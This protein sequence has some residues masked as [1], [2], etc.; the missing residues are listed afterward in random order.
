MYFSSCFKASRLSIPY[1]QQSIE[2]ARQS[3][4]P[5]THVRSEIRVTDQRHRSKGPLSERPKHPQTSNFIYLHSQTTWRLSETRQMLHDSKLVSVVILNYRNP[6]LTK[7]CVTQ[8]RQ[9]STEAK[10]PVQ[11][12]VV[13]NSAPETGVT[14]R[15]LLPEDVVLIENPQNLGFSRGNN[16]GILTSTGEYI[17]ILNN[18]AF[19]NALSL[20]TGVQ[21]MEEHQ[22]VGIWA[23]RLTSE[24]GRQ[25]ISVSRFPSLKGLF[26]AYVL[27]WNYDWYSDLS[28]FLAPRQVDM[29]IAACWL[30]RREVVTRVGLFDEAFFFNVED[31][32]YCKR[33]RHAGF[34]VA[35]DPCCSV[36]HLV[37]KS[38]NERSWTNLHGSLIIYFRKY[39]GPLG[40]L[41]AAWIIG[42]GLALRRFEKWSRN[43]CRNLRPPRML[44]H[45]THNL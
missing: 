25:Q 10:I 16:Q 18:D 20:Q 13:D 28:S 41:L 40:G 24:D 22:D 4:D 30:L 9:S 19:V 32:D 2:C 34:S 1:L 38:Q 12:I 8:V 45:R 5:W 14:L 27:A 21:Y 7:K 44:R 33:V 3:V 6:H 29:A 39:Y 17:L 15:G 37:G 23:P 35:Y 42:L 31:A 36:I 43:R 26:A 11:I